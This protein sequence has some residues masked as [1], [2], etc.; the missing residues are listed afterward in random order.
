MFPFFQSSGNIPHLK[1]LLNILKRGSIIAS[2]DIF[3]MQILIISWPWAVRIE[4]TDDYF[5]II[6]RE[7]NVC[8]ELIGNGNSWWGEDTVIFNNWA[9]LCKKRIKEI[10]FFTKICSNFVIVKKV[11]MQGTFLSFNIVF[12]NH[13]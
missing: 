9:L 6:L 4:F 11:W 8:Q 12:S 5:N 3:T 7:F 2:P 10:S 1:Q 13:Q